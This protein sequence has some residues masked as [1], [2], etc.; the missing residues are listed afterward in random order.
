MGIFMRTEG[1]RVMGEDAV[2][3]TN[4][5]SWGCR[6]YLPGPGETPKCPCGDGRLF[7]TR[8][9]PADRELLLDWLCPDGVPG[10]G[11]LRLE[12][13]RADGEGEPV[14]RGLP[15]DAAAATLTGLV[16]G[17]D[18]R[19]SL[20]AV[21]ESGRIVL[22]APERLGRPGPIP[23]VVVNYIHPEDYTYGFPGRSPASPSLL[24][25]SAGYLLASHDVYW[26]DGGQNLTKLFRSDDG[27]ESWT[28]PSVL[29]EGGHWTVGG[30]HKA[31]M[32]VVPHA[33]RLWSGIDHGSWNT[34]GHRS[35]AISASEDADL[36]DPKSW[37]VT[38]FLPYDPA[39][40]GTIAGGEKP[41]L[42]EGNIVVTPSGGLANLLRYNTRGGRP[43]YGKAI[44]LAVDKDN[45]GAPLRFAKVVDFH[46]D[47]SKFTVHLDGRTGR[48][49]SLVNRVSSEWVSQ[50]NI[51]TL[52]WSADLEHW[53]IASDLIDYEHNGWPEPREKVGFQY[54][55]WI[56]DGEDI[57][58]LSR[59]ALNGAHNYHNANHLT[60]HRLR[61]FRSLGARARRA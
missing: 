36:L 16:N 11:S 38:P 57:L 15:G 28:A 51:L 12:Y 4:A 31:P 26:G 33:G 37:T 1:D 44:M 27:G 35:G 30:P 40:S 49:W 54:V 6:H 5:P 2:A 22:E 60:F 50:R 42:L 10:H 17:A 29:M 41:H 43:E 47:M 25:H 61:D 39:W 52:V 19:I 24:R 20:S 56:F 58:F 48:Y 32:P 8:I 53:E 9:A 21:D 34:G 14:V 45:P 55:D 23:G 13:R 7:V 59:T 46:G 18:Y 3:E